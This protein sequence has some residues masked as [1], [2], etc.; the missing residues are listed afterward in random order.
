MQLAERALAGERRALARLLTLIEN[1]APEAEE[2]LRFLHHRTGRAS[3]LGVTGSAGTG[4]STLVGQLTKEFRQRN[5]TVGIVAVDPSSPFTRGAFLG[6][7]VRMQDLYEDPGVF[8]RSMATRGALG[9]LSE[10]TADVVS[11]MDAFGFDI[12]IVETVGA[13][14]DEVDVALLAHTIVVVTSPDSG[15]DMQVMKAGI[16]EIA[17]IYVVNKADQP[18]ADKMYGRLQAFMSLAPP[19]ERAKPIIQVSA[20]TG[21]GVVALADQ[22]EGHWQHLRETGQLEEAALERARRRILALARDGLLERVLE[23]AQGNGK[24]EALVQA[25]A[26]RE[27]D[28]HGA[29]EEL[30]SLV[31]QK[32]SS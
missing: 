13:G 6:D 1:K 22:I 26:S 8:I 16:L 7:R 19:S 4:K 21:M 30:M 14:Q 11:A 15:D 28:P 9:G 2:A 12:V 29:A 5:Y 24:L 3:T 10:T 17:D 31:K 27:L 20:L 23:V 18:G 25:V 32:K